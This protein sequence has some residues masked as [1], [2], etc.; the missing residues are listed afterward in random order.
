MD[1]DP[2]E[3]RNLK[4]SSVDR[5]SWIVRLEVGTSKNNEGRTVYLNDELKIIFQDLWNERKERGILLPYVFPNKDYTGKI[6]DF[7]GSW[8]AVFKK[9][10]IERKLFHD[11]R[12]TAVRNMVRTGIPERVAMQISGHKT[13]SVF[14]R[15]NI[16]NDSDLIK[17][18]KCLN[19]IKGKKICT[20]EKLKKKK[21][22]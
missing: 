15:Y 19:K 3:I 4:W 6:K 5:S 8:D 12:R 18:Q 16:V 20:I 21:S 11:L 7:R 14:D 22:S 10:G 17:A 9:T 2:G 13:R 1:G